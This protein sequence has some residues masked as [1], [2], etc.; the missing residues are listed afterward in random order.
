MPLWYFIVIQSFVML[1]N[2]EVS[3][4]NSDL[5]VKMQAYKD[6]KQQIK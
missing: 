5:S 1:I 6:T 4:M 3:S 2:K